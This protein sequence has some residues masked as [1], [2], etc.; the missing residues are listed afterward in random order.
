MKIQKFEDYSFQEQ[1]IEDFIS[2][3]CSV[4]E[5]SEDT[6]STSPYKKVEKKVISDLKLDMRLILTF[7]SGIGAFY[8][9]VHQMMDNYGIGQ[10]D[11]SSES[12]VLLTIAAFT[13]IYLEE[14]KSKTQEETDKLTKDSKSMLEELRMRGIGDGIVKKVMKSFSAIKNIFS[15]IAK[16]L[17]SAVAGIIDMLSY[18]AILVP[19]MNAI[20]YIVGKY[21]MTVDTVIQ[22]FI[23][24]GFGIT[25]KFAKHGLID[26]LNKLKDKIGINKKEVID[27]IETPIIQ[28][29]STFNDGETEEENG[30]LIKEQ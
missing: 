14:K 9:V 1:L 23:A 17:G 5:S 6:E 18:T 2:S 15:I 13:I 26:L 24:L 11:L 20:F 10:I 28:K 7:G 30:D 29:F 8:P 21:D 12:I 16:H 27:E 4:N 25:T 19:I 22:N 3:I